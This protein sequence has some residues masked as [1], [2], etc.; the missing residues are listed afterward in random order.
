M[1]FLQ[2]ETISSDGLID[3]LLRCHVE[4]N[5]IV[6]IVNNVFSTQTKI[7]I[8]N[9]NERMS[10]VKSYQDQLML[11]M[12]I[13]K[14]EQRSEEWHKTRKGIV[15]ASEFAQALGKA[16]FGTQR[17]WFQKKSGYEEDKFNPSSPPLKWGTMFEQVAGDI[18]CQRYAC[19]MHEFGLIKHPRIKHFGAS[20]DGINNF[21]IMV[22][23]K[24]PYQ[25]KITGEIPQQYYFQIQ[26]QLDTC[27]LEECD[28]VECEFIEYHSL[29]DWIRY[30]HDSEVGIIAEMPSSDPFN[31]YAYEYSKIWQSS[32][33]AHE[34]VRNEAC[35]W[36]SDQ[37]LRNPGKPIEFHFWSLGTF[38]CVRVYKDERFLAEKMDT[39]QD[40]W[41]KLE[42][43]RGDRELYKKE[44]ARKSSAVTSTDAPSVVEPPKE[45]V[46]EGYA[47]LDDA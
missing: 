45:K 19:S 37:H 31:P 47:F 42:N 35:A 8:Q 10:T 33:A 5:D 4:I 2:Q 25:R 6:M 21:G 3:K 30:P 29:E 1:A 34:N 13:P 14:I 28:Y 22:E 17:Q 38:N 23:I 26:G 18:Y 9:V 16:K 24:C 11:L 12:S 41:Y 36:M 46:L 7:T 32:E 20:P 39:L 43:Y 44:I 40:I 15:T 27:G